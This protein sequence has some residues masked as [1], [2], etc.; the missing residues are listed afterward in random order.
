MRSFPPQISGSGP[1]NHLGLSWAFNAERQNQDAAP[2]QHARSQPLH[3][4]LTRCDFRIAQLHRATQ[5]TEMS[6]KSESNPA[7]AEPRPNRKKEGNVR[8]R[9][10]QFRKIEPRTVRHARAPL[11]AQRNYER[12]LA[13]AR[14]EAQTGDRVAAENYLQ[15][16][17][18]Y[19]RSMHQN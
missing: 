5:W 6:I 3:L 12:Y 18:H 10:H 4:R 8:Q 19:F 7:A 14:A 15:H 16:A 2:S 9:R 1:T 13:L 17:E 11:D